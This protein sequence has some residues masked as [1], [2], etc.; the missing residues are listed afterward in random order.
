ML[1]RFNWAA[2]QFAETHHLAGTVGS[3][4]HATFELGQS[5]MMLDPFEGADGLRNVIRRG[6]SKVR[7]SPPWFHVSSRYAVI[8]KKVTGQK[9]TGGLD[10]T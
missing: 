8:Y 6:I 7:W 9:V 2:R 5:L 4:A 3:D 1:P 10:I